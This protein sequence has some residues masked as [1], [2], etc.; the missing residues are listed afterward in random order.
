MNSFLNTNEHFK[1]DIKDD[2]TAA[3]PEV[4]MKRRLTIASP[5]DEIPEDANE[6]PEPLPE[7]G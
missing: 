7:N 3:A 5:E 4:L 6:I 2:E 1:H